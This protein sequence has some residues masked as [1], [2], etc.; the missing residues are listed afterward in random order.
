MK[1][2]A[3]IITVYR[4]GSHADVLV[5]K[6]LQGFP[7]D[8]ELLE[9]RVEIASMYIDQAFDDDMSQELSERFDI[10][11]YQS[12]V[13]AMTLGGKDLAVDGVLLI[14]EHGDYAWNEKE[15]HLYPRRYFMEQITGVMAKAGRG[16][17]VYNDKHLSWR[18]E[19]ARWM[20]DRAA[21]LGAP[22]MAGS[23]LPVAWRDPFLEHDLDTP[24]KEAIAVGFSGLDIYGFHTLEVL[25]CMVERRAGGESGVVAVT[26][27]EGEQAWAHG[28]GE[29]A[30][31]RELAEAACATVDGSGREEG[32]M[33]DHCENP[34]LFLVE[35]SDG[36]RGAVVML[37]GYLR[38]LAYASR[39]QEG[40]VE[41]TW[42]KCQGHG[43][44]DGAYAHFSYLGLNVE[45][46]F[47]T[48][49]P[50]YPLERTLLTT[51]VLEAALTSRHE[52]H[53]RLETPWLEFGYRSYEQ[54]KFQPTAPSPT[55]SCL[56]PFPPERG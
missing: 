53:V 35:Y 43:G 20:A 4:P 34:A 14:G 32:A 18:W 7:T 45:E 10:P 49:Q 27:L 50:Q 54:L 29:G 47:I 12:I 13:G 3:A 51:G 21:E 55:G 1:K 46:M 25:Q 42:F 39:R 36:F 8:G 22:F 23:S 37:N 6:F 5:G 16:V 28:Q 33:E 11:I 24:L 41:A 30:W 2:I 40:A 15:Q 19:D 44:E 56:D 31:W 52:G 17:P 26:C 9:P 38:E 48:G